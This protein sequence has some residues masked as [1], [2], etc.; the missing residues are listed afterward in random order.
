[1]LVQIQESK[2]PRCTIRLFNT[3]KNTIASVILRKKEAIWRTLWII[4]SICRLRTYH[5]HRKEISR[6]RNTLLQSNS[7][8]YPC[9]VELDEPRGTCS[10]NSK[11]IIRS[12][13][14]SVGEIDKDRALRGEFSRC[15]TISEYIWGNLDPEDP[16]PQ[17]HGQGNE[18]GW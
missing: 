1:M 5:A 2:I 11:G 8:S 4:R 12:T 6:A 13:P 9:R 16:G 14:A 17:G 15:S 3:D 18:K 7:V 10:Q